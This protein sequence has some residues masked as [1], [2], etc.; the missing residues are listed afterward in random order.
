MNTDTL[1][2]ILTL[3]LEATQLELEKTR[4]QLEDLKAPNV[5]GDT[6]FDNLSLIPESSQ[7]AATGLWSR[8]AIANIYKNPDPDPEFEV[9][10]FFCVRYMHMG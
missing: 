9:Q 3:A 1:A 7:G 10:E 2:Y 4:M 6:G 5:I 8:E